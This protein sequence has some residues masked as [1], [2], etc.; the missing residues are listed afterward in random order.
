MATR[1]IFIVQRTSTGFVQEKPVEFHWHAGLAVSQKQKSI[2]DL[3]AAARTA[4][5][6]DRILEI[7]SKSPDVLGVA[8]SA[9]NL[10]LHVGDRRVPVEVAFQ[11]SKV[12]LNGGPF[13][14]LLNAVPRDAK[15]DQRLKESGRLVSFNFQAGDWPLHPTTAFYDWLY[16]NALTENPE[17]ALLLAEFQAFTDIEFNPERSINCQ[18]R[19]AA[20]YVGLKRDGLLAAVM[21]SRDFFMQLMQR[22]PADA[23][24][25]TLC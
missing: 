11:S 3:H 9:F 1:P 12:F 8:L 21:A 24:Q 4:T 18:A 2:A 16:L 13:L 6:V 14:D 15:A 5:G 10:K 19:S 23:A 17:L 7:S 22:Q 25:L 20:L